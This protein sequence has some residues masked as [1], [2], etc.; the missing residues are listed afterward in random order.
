MF[1]SVSHSFSQS[2]YSLYN[3]SIQGLMAR[4]HRR[5]SQNA[6]MFTNRGRTAPGFRWAKEVKFMGQAKCVGACSHDFDRKKL[7]FQPEKTCTLSSQE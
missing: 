1:F 5:R 6:D 4:T 3:S 2:D 7:L